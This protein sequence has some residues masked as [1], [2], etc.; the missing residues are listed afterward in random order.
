MTG[1][2]IFSENKSRYRGANNTYMYRDYIA[3]AGYNYDDRYVVNAE[4]PEERRFVPVDNSKSTGAGAVEIIAGGG[5][6]NGRLS[7]TRKDF[8]VYQNCTT[9]TEH[10]S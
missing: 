6:R 1:R 9:A 10:N 4:I 5:G 2:L 7:T 3:S 8:A